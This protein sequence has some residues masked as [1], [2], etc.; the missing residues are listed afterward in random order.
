MTLN[1]TNN[2]TLSCYF[3]SKL[4]YVFSVSWDEVPKGHLSFCRKEKK[5]QKTDWCNLVRCVVASLRWVCDRPIRKALAY[6]AQK[7]ATVYPQ[8]LQE[9]LCSDGV[10]TS[11]DSLL[12][13]ETACVENEHRHTALYSTS[14]LMEKQNAENEPT[15]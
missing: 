7:M 13:Q 2:C 4:G 8:S 15:Q 6:I 3:G 5:L 1:G 14:Q 10:D 11:Y 9:E 12:T